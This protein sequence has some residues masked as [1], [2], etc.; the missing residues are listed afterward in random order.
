MVVGLKASDDVIQ[1]SRHNI[2]NRV[3]CTVLILLALSAEGFRVELTRVER[4]SLVCLLAVSPALPQLV[5]S[6][7]KASGCYTNSV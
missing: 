1:L 2:W 7:A 3:W 5:L 6:L 4:V